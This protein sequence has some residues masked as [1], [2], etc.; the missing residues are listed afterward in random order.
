MTEKS[1]NVPEEEGLSNETKVLEVQW[2][3]ESGG[4]ARGA[5][6]RGCFQAK[7]CLTLGLLRTGEWIRRRP[8][9][10]LLGSKEQPESKVRTVVEMGF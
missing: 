2:Q 9:S 4:Q 10:C 8:Q 7:A 3:L 5:G 6:L 1:P